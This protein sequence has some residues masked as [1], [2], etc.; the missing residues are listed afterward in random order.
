MLMN[1]AEIAPLAQAVNSL[2]K[3]KNNDRSG[4]A[5]LYLTNECNY[6]CE[7]CYMNSRPGL[8]KTRLNMPLLSDVVSQLIGLDEIVLSGGEPFIHPDFD[9]VLELSSRAA[10][11]V[12]VYTN[13]LSLRKNMADK[14][15]TV[16]PNVEIV[17]PVTRY[18]LAHRGH[19]ETIKS[20]VPLAREWM[21]R[22]DK[23]R[24]RFKVKCILGD[25]EDVSM[26]IRRF[27]LDDLLAVGCNTGRIFSDGRAENLRGAY[28]QSSVIG[29]DGGIYINHL[30]VYA[31]ERAL[32][33][34]LH[35]GESTDDR[36][37]TI[38]NQTTADEIT[39]RVNSYL[40]L[41]SQELLLRS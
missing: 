41:I 1:S 34:E 23:P 9:A 12:R 29:P 37:C 10:K 38:A 3:Y 33:K 36:I 27:G 11:S 28:Q 31:N 21:E 7:C 30:G 40:H 4:F 2:G 22:A 8:T 15:S 19:E 20:A 16:L 25:P 6:R 5:F 24:I 32:L 14:L 18:H 17:L 39:K 35:F 13:G 26:L